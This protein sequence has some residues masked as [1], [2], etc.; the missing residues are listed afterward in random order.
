MFRRGNR[1]CGQGRCR[2]A[3]ARRLAPQSRAK[4]TPSPV[5]SEHGREPELVK[6][7]NGYE[8]IVLAR[9]ELGDLV[10]VAIAFF[11]GVPD[12]IKCS[13]VGL[14]ILRRKEARARRVGAKRS[15]V[16]AWLFPVDGESFVR[17][18]DSGVVKTLDS[19]ALVIGKA[20][21]GPVE[22]EGFVDVGHSSKRSSWQGKGWRG[23]DWR[24]EGVHFH[25]HKP[26]YAILHGESEMLVRINDKSTPPIVGGHE[27]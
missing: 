5:A 16:A 19:G 3:V 18:R 20:T 8:S 4:G 24:G 1:N 15:D 10:F 14:E 26:A 23:E 2:A 12:V 7:V 13:A 27:G 11:R 25:V 6:E 21:G 17:N 22:D 9:G